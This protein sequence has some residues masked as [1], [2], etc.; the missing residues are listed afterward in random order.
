MQIHHPLRMNFTGDQPPI[1]IQA[2]NVRYSAAEEWMI[3][4]SC[5]LAMKFFSVLARQAALVVFFKPLHRLRNGSLKVFFH[6]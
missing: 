3:E 6:P 1:T 2:V 4:I 5:F